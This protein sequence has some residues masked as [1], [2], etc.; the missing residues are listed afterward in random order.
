MTLESSF[1]GFSQ[2]NGALTVNARNNDHHSCIPI[3]IKTH[4]HRGVFI[5]ATGY[6]VA[7][8]LDFG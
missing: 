2:G 4:E 1:Q 5:C 6:A 3:A 7:F 8:S